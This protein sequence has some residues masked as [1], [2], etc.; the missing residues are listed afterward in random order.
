[1]FLTLYTPTYKRPRQLLDCMASVATQSLVGEI[2]HII[3][4][5]YLGVGVDGM[6]AR[7]PLYAPATHGD[8]V[9][10]LA[11][12]DRIA[13]KHA[14]ERLREFAEK[15]GSPEVIVCR[16]I[17]GGRELPDNWGEAPRLGHFD[18]GN[19]I[20]RGDIWRRHCDQ[21]GKRYEGDYDFAA[22]LWKHCSWAWWDYLFM[23]GRVNFGRP[24]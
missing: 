8:Y 1:M 21:Y 23:V 5:D 10:L 2:E 22:F 4:P 9:Y 11:D 15:N 17:K 12:D 18:L 16:D 3:I 6:Y 7:V 24:E 13:D 14:V 19:M 20:V